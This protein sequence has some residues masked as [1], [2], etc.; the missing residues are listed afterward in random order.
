[1]AIEEDPAPSVPEWVVTFGDMMSLLLTFFIMLVSLS[2]T[3]QQEKYQAMLDSI[4]RQFGY[5]TSNASVEPGN[6]RTRSGRDG[7]P[8]SLGRAKLANT[9]S[10]GDK[11][12]APVG[13][14][15]RVLS[16]RHGDKT[17]VAGVARFDGDSVELT[18]DA[19]RQLQRLVM[20]IVGKPQKIEIRGHASRRPL[21]PGSPYQDHWELCY[22]RCM[23]TL[24][25]L[26]ELG[27][28]PDRVRLSQAGEFE[29]YTTDPQHD[30]QNPRVEVFLLDEFAQD[31]AGSKEEQQRRLSLE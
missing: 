1:M 29:P 23:A 16:L 2:E 13:E 20:E 10:G 30:E 19:R 6:H 17:V 28:S 31:H 27:V 25:F 7:T 15:P 21:P 26:L 4:Q 11:V 3:K 22:A 18:E 24:Q 14:H 5:T 8:K 9:M 12:R